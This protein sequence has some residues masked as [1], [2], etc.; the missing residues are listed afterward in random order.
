LRD[1]VLYV[2]GSPPRHLVA[3]NKEKFIEE[4]ESGRSRRVQR[5]GRCLQPGHTARTCN[6]SV[7]A[8][9]MTTQTQ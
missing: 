5:C 3:I 7:D 2:E 9:S 6:V 8:P 4:N 1:G